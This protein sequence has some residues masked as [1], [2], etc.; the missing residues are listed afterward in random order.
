M[1]GSKSPQYGGKA[2]DLA[3][4]HRQIRW[5]ILYPPCTIPDSL[6]CCIYDGSPLSWA[7]QCS[8]WFSTTE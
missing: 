6:D 4:H 5:K 2:E 7:T 3:P 1:E 8:T